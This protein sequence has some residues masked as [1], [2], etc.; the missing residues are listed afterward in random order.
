MRAIIMVLT[1][2]GQLL[3]WDFQLKLLQA[4]S[5]P[6][7]RRHLDRRVPH[8]A[9]RLLVLACRY[10][11]LNV[12]LDPDLKS[13]PPNPA[14]V[15]A[16]HQSVAD[17]V[18]LPDALSAH[19]VRFVAKR[20]LA[21]GFPAVSEVLRLQ[22]HALIN[23]KGDFKQGTRELHR[24]GR[25]THEGISPV[26]F[27]EGTRSRTGAVREFHPGGVRTILSESSVPIVAVA[28]DG[29]H[30]FVSMKDIVGGLSEITYRAKLVGVF[31]HD[32][33]KDSIRTALRNAHDAVA[34]QI[35]R[36]RS[37]AQPAEAVFEIAE[38]GQ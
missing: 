7:V 17:I 13:A 5:R 27:P 35:E 23:R 33:G 29:G 32:G 14:L 22:G 2:L 11:G 10:G 6:A 12:D 4:L 30:R 15:C 36:W 9:H 25:E 18:V 37:E 38:E 16:N 8:M 28:V 1:I 21:R 19:R 34:A 3:A 31:E 26:V 20:E 24:I